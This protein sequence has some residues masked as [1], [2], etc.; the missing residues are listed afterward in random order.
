MFARSGPMRSCIMALWRLSIQVRRAASTMANPRIINS[1]MNAAIMIEI[2]VTLGF[3]QSEGVWAG[4]QVPT[5]QHLQRRIFVFSFV[6]KGC[7]HS[8]LAVPTRGRY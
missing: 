3:Q 1:L 5:Q 6:Q 8:C 4:D 7:E 2:I